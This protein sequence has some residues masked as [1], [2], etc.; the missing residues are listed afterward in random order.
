MTS[1]I[2]GVSI[3]CIYLMI[4]YNYSGRVSGRVSNRVIVSNKPNF[5]RVLIILMCCFCSACIACSSKS[6]N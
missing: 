4:T 3:E 5:S 6:S 2:T 1:N